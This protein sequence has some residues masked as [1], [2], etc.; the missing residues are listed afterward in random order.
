MFYYWI[1]QETN[2]GKRWDLQNLK[3]LQASLVKLSYQNTFR[4]GNPRIQGSLQ[5]CKDKL[6]FSGVSKL[7]FLKNHSLNIKTVSY[8]AWHFVS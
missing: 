7:Y 1:F 8:Q 5:L 3:I 6:I 2:K 4:S